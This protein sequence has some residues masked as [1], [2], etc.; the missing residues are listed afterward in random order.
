MT[1]KE[2]L[3]IA[4]IGMRLIVT[5]IFFIKL[6]FVIYAFLQVF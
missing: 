3:L 1:L 4:A 2:A 5:L 6:R